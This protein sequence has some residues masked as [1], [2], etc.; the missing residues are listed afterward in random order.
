MY[1]GKCMWENVCG[2]MYSIRYVYAGNLI[3]VITRP[4]EA[5]SFSQPVSR[6]ETS[7]QGFIYRPAAPLT[8]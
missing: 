6:V 8:E 4:L 2:K 3:T 5:F 1:V 7:E